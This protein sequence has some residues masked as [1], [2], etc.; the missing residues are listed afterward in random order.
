MIAYVEFRLHT[1]DGPL[2][3]LAETAVPIT[4]EILVKNQVLDPNVELC[5]ALH[6]LKFWVRRGIGVF[7]ELLLNGVET[8]VDFLLDFR[9]A[10]ENVRIGER[11]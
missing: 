7:L 5:K 11:V 10:R 9:K 6:G 4:H 8:S 1:D 2:E 3:R